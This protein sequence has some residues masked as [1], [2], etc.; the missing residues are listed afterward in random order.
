[1]N[2]L[3]AKPINA[4]ESDSNSDSEIQ[5]LLN[6]INNLVDETKSQKGDSPSPPPEPQQPAPQTA[7]PPVSNGTKREEFFPHAPKNFQEDG[8]NDSQIGALVLK[9]LLATGD[10]TGREISDQLKLPFI[11]MEPFLAQL[12]T[13]QLIGFGWKQRICWW[14]VLDSNQ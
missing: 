9:F 12:K 10:T 5:N 6:R 4:M 1:M 8:V 11:L 3:G 14:V 7:Q 2:P 13:D